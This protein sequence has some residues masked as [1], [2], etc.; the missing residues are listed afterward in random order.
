MVEAR[1]HALTR[2]VIALTRQVPGTSGTVLS[3]KLD[4]E[5][6]SEGSQIEQVGE[7]LSYVVPR[8]ADP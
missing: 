5:R 4:R 6:K 8:I 3:S 7:P 2:L 1:L